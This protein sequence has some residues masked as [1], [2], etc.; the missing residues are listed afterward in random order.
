M[1][2]Q[3]FLVHSLQSGDGAG[4]L[5]T[6]PR[7]LAMWEWLSFFV[8]KLIAGQ[9]LSVHSETEEAAIVL[10]GGKCIADWGEG[11]HRID[12]CFRLSRADRRR[13]RQG[14]LGRGGAEARQP[15]AEVAEL[16]QVLQRS[17]ERRVGKECENS[18]GVVGGGGS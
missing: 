17:E 5:L 3:D 14:G 4:D 9:S 6:L 8:H 13:R 15:H 11:Q 16:A 12:A 1:T 10:L 7:E 2:A 18:S